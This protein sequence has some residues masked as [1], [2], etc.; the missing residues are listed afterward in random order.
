MAF[1]ADLVDMVSQRGD[2]RFTKAQVSAREIKARVFDGGGTLLLSSAILGRGTNA[3]D[4]IRLY[5][6]GAEGV[7]FVGDTVL[8]G[9]VVDIAGTKV[10]IDRGSRVQLSNPAGT[11]IYADSHLYN[12][13]T[14]GNFTGIGGGAQVSPGNKQPFNARPGF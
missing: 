14:N 12:N 3:S 11:C 5:G 7:R 10:T 6:E 1:Y 8:R 9:N 13:G 2:I 4:L